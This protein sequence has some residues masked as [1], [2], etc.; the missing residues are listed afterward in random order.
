MKKITLKEI[1]KENWQ[2]ALY[3]NPNQDWIGDFVYSPESFV[4]LSMLILLS[5]EEKRKAKSN[6]SFLIELSQ[7]IR[8]NFKEFQNRA[9]KREEYEFILKQH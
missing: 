1:D 5:E 3:E 7:R 9:L 6:R 2:F 4:D 8:S